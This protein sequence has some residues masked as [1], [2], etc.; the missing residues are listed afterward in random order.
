M[1]GV[2]LKAQAKK[3]REDF[4]IKAAHNLPLTVKNATIHERIPCAHA[5]DGMHYI[6]AT[7]KE[8]HV[9]A[10]SCEC[11][12]YVDELDLKIEKEIHEGEVRTCYDVFLRLE[13][14]IQKYAMQGHEF[15]VARMQDASALPVLS[16]L[17]RS[18]RHEAHTRLTDARDTYAKL[19]VRL[20][21][22]AG[23][24]SLP[25]VYRTA[26]IVRNMLRNYFHPTIFNMFSVNVIWESVRREV[27][28]VSYKGTG[29]FFFDELLRP[30]HFAN[31]TL[32]MDNPPKDFVDK[33]LY[34]AVY[35]QTTELPDD[36]ECMFCSDGKVYSRMKGHLARKPHKQQEHTV[37]LRFFH[38]FTGYR[39]RNLRRFKEKGYYKHSQAE[40]GGFRRLASTELVLKAGLTRA[41]L[42]RTGCPVPDT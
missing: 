38:H 17:L 25:R 20:S 28:K 10:F 41:G 29:V 30:T 12:D 14:F 4:V 1:F 19:G 21:E 32:S 27:I 42:W 39:A 2:D 26:Y 9:Q 8:G 36:S 34:G 35:T 6:T 16:P 37:L 40:L 3:R 22:R 11:R 18:V 7:I 31:N 24:Y 5:K 33:A 15:G 23:D 13:M